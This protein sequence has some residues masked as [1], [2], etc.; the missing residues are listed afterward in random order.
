MITV[1]LAT[2]SF[3]EEVLTIYNSYIDGPITMLEDQLALVYKSLISKND[4]ILQLVVDLPAVQK[5]QNCNNSGVFAIAFAVHFT[6]GDD[7]NLIIFEESQMRNHLRK[8]FHRKKF[9]P[10]PSRQ[11]A[12]PKNLVRVNGMPFHQILLCSCLRP[13]SCDDNKEC[14]ECGEAYHLRCVPFI[15][16]PDTNEWICSN[17][18]H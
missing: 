16:Q 10:F 8:C 11:V 15:K 5:P 6:L 14:S 18:I 17:T 12:S 3:R 13:I 9:E 2:S 1:G 4:D 7:L